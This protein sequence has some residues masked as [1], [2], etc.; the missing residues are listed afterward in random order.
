VPS[1]REP[2]SLRPHAPPTRRRARC[3]R[4]ARG[5]PSTPRS[6]TGWSPSRWPR[7]AGRT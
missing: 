7:R 3:R 1:R 5:A 6:P 2:A 4:P